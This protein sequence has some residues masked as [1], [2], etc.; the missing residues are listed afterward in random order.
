MNT[1][2]SGSDFLK[3]LVGGNLKPPL[4]IEGVVKLA[5]DPEAI[6]FSEGVSCFA[7]VRIPVDMIDAVDLVTTALCRGDTYPYVQI[8]LKEVTDNP[9][10]ALFSDLLRMSELNPQPLPPRR[11]DDLNPQPLPPR[12]DDDL[13]PQP[14]PPRR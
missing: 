5:D 11:D 6:L 10:A 7:W 13:N 2:Y 9:E 1:S 3:A 8:R 14:L 12:R 4:V